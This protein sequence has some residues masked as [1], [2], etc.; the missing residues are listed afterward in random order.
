MLRN[1]LW[2]EWK[3]IRLTFM[4]MLIAMLLSFATSHFPIHLGLWDDFGIIHVLPWHILFLSC[5]MLGA[6][7]MVSDDRKVTMEFLISLPVKKYAIWLAKMIIRFP[8][9]LCLII[10]MLIIWQ[11]EGI[12]AEVLASIFFFVMASFFSVIMGNVI[13]A[14]LTGFLA[15]I[16][17]NVLFFIMRCYVLHIPY[18]WVTLT[19]DLGMIAIALTIIFASLKMFLRKYTR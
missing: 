2:N 16:I 19:F 9:V 4:L 5:G 6:T 12:H 7:F 8:L 14:F 13:I 17:Y 10:I 3:H 18:K 11:R 15:T 1:L